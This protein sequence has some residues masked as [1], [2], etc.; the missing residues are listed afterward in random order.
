MA[1]ALLATEGAGRVEVASAGSDPGPGVHPLAVAALAELGIDWRGRPVRGIDAVVD[2]P[3]DAVITV[4]DAARDGCPYLPGARATAHW[5]L[6]DP[7]AAAGDDAARLAAFRSARDRLHVA[8][9]AFLGTLGGANGLGD[10]LA[11]G[12]RAL[13]G[14]APTAPPAAVP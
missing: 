7:A 2:A 6:E 3:W 12:H 5:G 13:A 4:C 11:A 9:R 14:T 8:A 10:A 1:E